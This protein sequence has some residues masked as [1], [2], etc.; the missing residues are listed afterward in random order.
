MSI[1]YNIGIA[2]YTLLIRI[3]S[4]F[5][6]KAKAWVK[7]RRGWRHELEKAFSFDDKIIWFHAAS[8][9]EFEQGRP[10]IEAM[11]KQYP[12]HKIFL[13]F[14]SP[15]GYLQ[16]KDYD[17]AD[18][19]MYLPPDC[20]RNAHFF[21]ETLHPTLA[22]FI[23]YEFWYNYLAELKKD[24]V[25]TIFISATFRKGQPFFKCYGGRFRKI[26]KGVDHFFVQDQASVDMLKTIGIENVTLSGDTRFDR[27]AD[28]LQNK[29]EHADIERFCKN[30]K[31]LL[32]GSSWPP[33]EEILATLARKF[34]ELKIIIAPHEVKEERIT[35]LIQT[36]NM[37][38]ARYTRDA[39]ASWSDKQVLI[40]DTIGV[41]SSI[42]R[43]A[44]IA[45][46]GGAFATG[47]HNIQE[48]AVNGMPVIFGPKYHKFREA[49]DLVEKGG[50]FTV[51][52]KEDL[53]DCIG[54][55]IDDE[56]A[57]NAACKIS[58]EYMLDQTGATDRIMKG[59]RQYLS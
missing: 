5:N 54:K 44:D 49:I 29:S 47:L 46:I 25:P 36:L 2:L 53:Q 27:V 6:G 38:V 59:I 51:N 58:G 50:A 23:K 45:Y 17:G 1:L 56:A 16:K 55:L 33:D 57:Y 8:L 7:G 22:I 10:V 37:D 13:T 21:V 24:S 42:Y 26:L 9:G 41:L 4:L 34:P 32:V 15:S 39:A 35:Q 18:K 28:I 52:S 40:I 43:Y 19:V 11:R 12:S 14:F 3:A 48:P 20:K 31:T 30:H